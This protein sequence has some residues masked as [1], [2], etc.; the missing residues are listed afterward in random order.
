M[1]ARLR[2]GRPP[3]LG[4]DAS[5]SL[6]SHALNGASPDGLQSMAQPEMPS[7]IADIP[8]ADILRTTA[9][10]PTSCGCALLCRLDGAVTRFGWAS[11][12]I[13]AGLRPGS[14]T[15]SAAATSARCATRL[16]ALDRPSPRGRNRKARNTASRTGGTGCRPPRQSSRREVLPSGGHGTILAR[17]VLV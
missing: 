9:T 12:A 2:A 7:H 10:R 13:D 17:A 15:L 5:Y 11:R 1:L 8:L 3:P 4:D 16:A 6:R 14:R